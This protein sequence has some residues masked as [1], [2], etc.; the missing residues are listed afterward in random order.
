MYI[1]IYTY[2]HAYIFASI[3]RKL[4]IFHQC[5][6][7]PQSRKTELIFFITKAC[8]FTLKETLA[9]VFSCEFAKF[10]RTPFFTEHLR[11]LLLFTF[12]FL[13]SQTGKYFTNPIY[14]YKEEKW[15]NF[16]YF[17]T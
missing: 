6:L 16:L 10:L 2:I 11:W 14:H 15:S 1:Y 4:K 9:Q 7:I 5:L 13:F 3:S 17:C 8:N 12:L